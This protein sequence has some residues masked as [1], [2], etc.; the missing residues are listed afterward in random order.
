MKELIR[1][2]TRYI[3]AAVCIGLLLVLI[4]GAALVSFIV[5]QLDTPALEY[6]VRTFSEGLVQ[7]ETGWHLPADLT[8]ELRSHYQ[9]AMLLDAD[10]NVVWSDRL[11]RELDRRYSS[12][13]VAAFSRWYLDDYPVY[14]Y[15]KGDNLCVLGAEQGSRWK[16]SM[17]M[18]RH[19]MDSILDFLPMLVVLNLAALLAMTLLLGVRL[20]RRL[21]P[22]AQGV[23]ALAENQPV[24]LDTHGVLGSLC[25]DLNQTSEA[26]RR[27][28]A[29]LQKRDRAR[30][31]WIAGVS[32]DV[33]TPLSIVMGTAAQLESDPALSEEAHRRAQAI[34]EQS[35]RMGKLI[36]DLNLASKLE[37]GMQ[38]LHKE[39]LCPAAL[40]RRAAAELLNSGLGGGCEWE[41]GMDPACEAVVLDGDAALLERAV[42]NLLL[43]C[44]AHNPGGCTVSV[45]LT[46]NAAQCTI[47]V[48]DNGRGF[49]DEV[50]RRLRIPQEATL[51]H[52]GLGLTIVQQILRAHGGAAVFTNTGRGAKA[53]LTLP[54]SAKKP[55]P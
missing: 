22:V 25:A 13:D 6:K 28:E 18:E 9:W 5:S 10:G 52:H 54:R 39:P 11:P 38:P 27:Q 47:T 43:N 15:R 40:V 16:Y 53:E 35:E 48:E 12:A 50:L 7:D 49:P 31:E 46:C 44:I 2:L 30:T 8:D 33:R 51:H 42:H 41:I 1:I 21:R 3:G 29:L 20:Y 14:V 37:Y 23:R 34:R 45:R 4:N 17:E 19:T 32:H 55:A 36:G 26:L 24:Q